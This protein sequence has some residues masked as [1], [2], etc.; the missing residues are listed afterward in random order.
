MAQLEGKG[1]AGKE[2]A[3]KVV[4][5]AAAEND[6]STKEESEKLVGK[7][8]TENDVS[9]KELAADDEAVSQPEP[10]FTPLW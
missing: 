5:K 10:L 4:G 1:A 8:A 3:E 9:G 2:V 6:V 7:E